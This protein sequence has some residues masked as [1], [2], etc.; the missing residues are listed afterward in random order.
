M[1]KQKRP[2]IDYRPQFSDTIF[3][4][5]EVVE[6]ERAD[7]PGDPDIPSTD[8]S[9]PKQTA[10]RNRRA[11]AREQTAD[12]SNEQPS[13]RTND[14]PNERTNERS[15]PAPS[16]EVANE[17]LSVRTNE[18]TKKRHSFDI[19]TDQLDALEALQ[20]TLKA[21]L[22]RKPAIGELVQ[23]ALDDFIQKMSIR[24]SGRSNERT[25]GR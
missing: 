5:K 4:P 11:P 14:R 6:H 1:P 21:T 9:T 22:K 2:P 12:R 19:Y 7:F 20:L 17:Q 18:R 16:R 8:T 3:R 23:Q 15:R 13:A 24:T 25:S 10:S